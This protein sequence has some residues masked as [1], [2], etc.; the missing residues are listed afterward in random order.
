[1]DNFYT[2]LIGKGWKQHGK[3][4]EFYDCYHLVKEIQRRR[5]FFLPEIDTPES[6][7]MRLQMFKKLCSKFAESIDKP[8]PFCVVVFDGG[9]FTRL[10]I[11]VVLEDCRSFIHSAAYIK[12]I[13]I[14]K[15][16]SVLWKKRVFGYFR[17]TK[18]I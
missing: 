4:P 17:C 2:N 9:R 7:E 1:M 15:L 8:E 13:R 10:H 3:G 5:G 6:I 18:K 12:R 11:G 14:D 16:D